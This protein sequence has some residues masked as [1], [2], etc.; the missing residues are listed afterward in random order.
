MSAPVSKGPLVIAVAVGIA[1]GVAVE[2]FV[3]K[4]GR[5]AWD[6]EQYWTVGLGL[7]FSAA[8][9]GGF[10]ARCK[11]WL[12]GYA[13]FAGQAVTMAAESGEF[14]LLPLGLMLMGVV[15]LPGV[16]LAYAGSWVGKRVLG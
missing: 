16:A 14:G 7:L 12:I 13:P 15:G 9:V 6:S 2:T 8:L 10:V 11:P 3:G 5:E 1:V 4:P